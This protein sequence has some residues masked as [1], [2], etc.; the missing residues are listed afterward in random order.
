MNTMKKNCKG[1]EK[2]NCSEPKEKINNDTKNQK[3]TKTKEKHDQSFLPYI[4]KVFYHV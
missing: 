2:K 4:F 3:K 1:I